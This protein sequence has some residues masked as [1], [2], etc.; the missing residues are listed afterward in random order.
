MMV[1]FIILLLPS[2]FTHP[3]PSTAEQGNRLHEAVVASPVTNYS[4]GK[5]QTC[6]LL[7]MDGSRVK[8]A[9]FLS[10]CDKGLDLHIGDGLLLKGEITQDTTKYARNDIDGIIKL[11]PDRIRRANIDLQSISAYERTKLRMLMIRESL[12]QMLRKK[13]GEGEFAIIAAMTLGDR[14]QLSRQKDI[15]SLFANTGVAHVLALSGLHIGVIFMFLS[16]IVGQGRRKNE[17]GIAHVVRLLL[18]LLAIWGFVML[19]GMPISAIRSATMISIYAFLSAIGRKRGSYNFNNNLW[20][21]SL[22]S[23]N[24][25]CLAGVIILVVSPASLKD[26]GF[27]LSFL[28]VAGILVLHPLLYPLLSQEKL[29]RTRP[30]L[31]ACI[32][33]VWAMTVISLSAQIATAPLVAYYFSSFSTVFLLS[34]YIVIPLATIILYS[35]ILFFA[36]MFLPV[37]QAY[38]GIFLTWLTGLMV[39]FLHLMAD[40]PFATISDIDIDRIEVALLYIIILLFFR[41]WNKNSATNLKILLVIFVIFIIK[42]QI[43]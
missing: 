2:S 5:V 8:M 26:I 33:K 18:I 4:S 22:L 13:T 40:L 30:R 6:E 32:D 38:I 34:N 10:P 7:L 19:V 21:S 42:L 35:T 37:V 25:L 23:F 16:R 29:R 12:L 36:V 27:Q 15:R 1:I 3:T 11:N 14:S 9:V 41:W 24:T 17:K 28:S 43:L 20:T 31:S 39:G